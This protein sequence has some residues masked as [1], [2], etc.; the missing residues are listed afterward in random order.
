M[1]RTTGIIMKVYMSF[2]NHMKGVYMN[3][4]KGV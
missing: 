2:M 1:V 3:Y 4:P